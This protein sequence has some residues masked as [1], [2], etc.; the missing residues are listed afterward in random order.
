MA[1]SGAGCRGIDQDIDHP[2]EEERATVVVGQKSGS[3][4]DNKVGAVMRGNTAMSS[5][6]MENC[7]EEDEDYRDRDYDN[8]DDDDLNYNDAAA[9]DN[10]DTN[11][12][13][14]H[15]RN[16]VD[17]ARVAE[18]YFELRKK[19]KGHQFYIWQKKLK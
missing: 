3:S 13:S 2:T 17:K 14:G 16:L 5:D 15:R 7:L 18:I 1:M 6:A 8:N 10:N 4:N 19:K 11:G 9:A 12:N